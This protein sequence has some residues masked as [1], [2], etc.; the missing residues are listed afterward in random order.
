MKKILIKI[1]VFLYRL[2]ACSVILCAVTLLVL[3][4][5][6]IHG[7]IV[8]TG[9]MEPAVHVGSICFV[10]HRTPFEDVHEGDIITFKAGE[11][12][13]VTHRAVGIDE[14]G[15]TTRG[16]ANNTDDTAKVTKNEFIGKNVFSLPY[17]G[18]FVMLMYSGRGRVILAEILLLFGI[19]GILYDR[20]KGE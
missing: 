6:G 8:K 20:I 9:S 19:A 11:T 18:N 14:S 16:D 17:I 3:Y 1:Y 10:N 2:T 7:Y 5:C 12:M 13:L 15:I 4:L